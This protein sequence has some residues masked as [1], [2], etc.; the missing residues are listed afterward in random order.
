M[1][2]WGFQNPLK[3]FSNCMSSLFSEDCFHTCRASPLLILFQGLTSCSPHP[4]GQLSL[5]SAPL[6]LGT[7]SHQGLISVLSTIPGK[8]QQHNDLH[9]RFKL[10]LLALDFTP[11]YVYSVASCKS[12]VQEYDFNLVCKNGGC[13]DKDDDGAWQTRVFKEP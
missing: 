2:F 5:A 6:W 7:I 11:C 12:S 13:N 4:W 9:T 3:S 10:T 8:L 1:F